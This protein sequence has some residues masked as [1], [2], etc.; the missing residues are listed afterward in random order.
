MRF[1]TWRDRHESAASLAL[2]AE[3]GMATLAENDSHWANRSPGLQPLV[4][5]VRCCVLASAHFG[6]AIRLPI[7]PARDEHETAR[8]ELLQ[9]AVAELQRALES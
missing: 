3:D 7:G 9:R 1:P 5:A 8:R 2:V 4:S 6:A